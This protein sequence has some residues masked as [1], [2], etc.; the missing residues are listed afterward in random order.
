[1]PELPETETIARDLQ[2]QVSGLGIADVE[3]SR[4]DVLRRVSPKELRT[5]LVG[6]RIERAWRRAKIVVLDF[7]SG[8]HLLVQPR[9]TGRLIVGGLT[10]TDPYTAVRLTLSDERVLRYDD[11]RRLGTVALTT[12][13]EFEAI[14]H[15]LGVEP[16]DPEFTTERLSG[17]LRLSSRAVKAVLMDQRAIAGIGNIY[18]S[19]AL[20]RAGL[21]PSRIASDLG[22][23]D[24]A[25]LREAVVDVLCEAVSAR[26][27]SFRDYR[28]GFGG[29]GG[30][31]ASLAVYGREGDACPRCGTR[32][33]STHAIDG[34]STFFCHRC[35]S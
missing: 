21:D 11:V 24:A 8:D 15:D 7:S 9:F 27:T 29:R 12:G 22:A 33:T 31:S 4:P 32:I 30:F 3:V 14:S 23:G 6:A 5:R 1:V 13:N 20:W 18:A 2:G 19:E 16:L 10:D 26:G 25:S 28:D 35:Q 34:R 17:I